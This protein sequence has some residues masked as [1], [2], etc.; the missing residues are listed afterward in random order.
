MR[1]LPSRFSSGHQ[2]SSQ[3]LQ[4]NSSW[5]YSLSLHVVQIQQQ[6]T[7]P[8]LITCKEASKQEKVTDFYRKTVATTSSTL[9]IS[10]KMRFQCLT[11][12]FFFLVSSPR[13]CL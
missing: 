9:D 1:L 11:G 10:I 2:P 13:H 3:A 12:L 4:V 5:T 7:S 6:L 8:F